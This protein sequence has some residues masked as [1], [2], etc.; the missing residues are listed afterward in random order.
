M[1]SMVWLLQCDLYSVVLCLGL[2][3]VVPVGV[4]VY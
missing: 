2:Y 3:R 1:A 4:T